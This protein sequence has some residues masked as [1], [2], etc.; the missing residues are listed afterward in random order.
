MAGKTQFSK[1][2]HGFERE[3]TLFAREL[4]LLVLGRVRFMIFHW[5]AHSAL[6]A[7]EVLSFVFYLISMLGI[8]GEILISMLGICGEIKF[9]R[10]S[11]E[12][13]AIEFTM[14]CLI[15]LFLF[16]HESRKDCWEPF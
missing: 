15:H 11:R 3:K 13:N 5:L 6:V 4:S 10:K 7:R 14:P 8:C 1:N 12:S 9:S 16:D 2:S